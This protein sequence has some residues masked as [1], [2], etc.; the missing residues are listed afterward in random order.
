MS[1]VDGVVG[2]SSSGIVEAPSFK[3]GTINI[4]DR[5]TGRIK[6]DSVIDCKPQKKDI[7]NAITIL[8]SEEFQQKLN[9][10]KNPYGD[11]NTAPKIK[12]II[13]NYNLNNIIKKEFFN[14]NFDM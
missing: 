1:F 8:Y 9:N 5:Q 2:N 14:L 12:E 4:G 7:L 10:V 6:A 3:I 13:K 11:G